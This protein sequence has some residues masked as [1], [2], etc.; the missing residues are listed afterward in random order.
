MPCSAETCV[1]EYWSYIAATAASLA[2]IGVSVSGVVESM[3][4]RKEKQTDRSERHLDRKVKIAI[5]VVAIADRVQREMV[6][7]RWPYESNEEIENAKSR[8]RIVG[9]S[10]T[11]IEGNED[12][13][14]AQI[15]IN[16]LNPIMKVQD[17]IVELVPEV[18]IVLGEK[19]QSA[20][21]ELSSALSLL[22]GDATRMILSLPTE[23]SVDYLFMSFEDKERVDSVGENIDDKVKKVEEECKLSLK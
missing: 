16:R 23:K 2:V 3:K 4:W 21:L 9:L 18:Q 19:V 17:E 5:R 10:E 20:L 22:R 7:V 6:H 13:V 12:A 11:Q 1:V 14:R 15:F 8:L